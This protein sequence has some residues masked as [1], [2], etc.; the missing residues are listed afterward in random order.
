MIIYKLVVSKTIG[1]FFLIVFTSNVFAQKWE[2]GASAGVCQYKGDVMPTFKPLIVR[3]GGS[4]FV[5]MNYSRSVSFKAQGLF[6]GVVGN[7]KFIKSDPYRQSREYSF[8]TILAE[9]SGQIEYNFLNFRTTSSR[10]VDNWTP[11]VFGGYGAT[12]IQTK[13]KIKTDITSTGSVFAPYSSNKTE[14]AMLLGIG[15][16]KQWRGQWN[17]GVEFGARHT[18]TDFLDNLG[19]SGGNLQINIPPGVN[20]SDPKF[21][22]LLKYQVPGTKAKDVYYYTN[23]SI[24]YV[25]YKVHCPTPR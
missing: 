23:F 19:Y 15:F 21:V 25:L 12:L 9:G 3:P 14:Q 5:R 22:Y 24:S 11:Y 13:S 20:P 18:T 10:I 8:N 6:G 16:K 4:V 1:L 2:V 17:W 7:D